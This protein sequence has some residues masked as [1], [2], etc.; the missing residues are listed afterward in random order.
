MKKIRLL[1]IEDNRLLRNGVM[2]I[3]KPHKD[4]NIVAASG[5]SKNTVLKIHKLK[6]N[7][8][9]LDLGLRSQNSLHVVEMV[10]KEFPEAKIIVMDLAPVQADILQ[11]VRAGASGFIL[12]DASLDDFLITIRLVSEGGKVLPPLLADS[13]FTQIVE[14]AVRSGKGKLKEAIK[15][16]KR[17]RE[18]IKLISA[19]MSNK[20]I[21]QKIHISSYTVKSHIHN[22]M[23][24]LALHTRL[25]VANYSFTDE[26]LKTIEKSIS[27]LN[28]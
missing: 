1:L 11:Y 16:T 10:R 8:V 2:S 14:Y 26:T 28:L 17:E 25:E 4:I 5:D 19:G 15:M 27:I 21:G 22:I 23:E 12:K 3:L 7:V 9:L 6:P 20:E 18:V 24:K 13:L